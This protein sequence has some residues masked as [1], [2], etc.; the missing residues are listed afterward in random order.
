MSERSDMGI[1]VKIVEQGSMTRAGRELRMTAGAVTKRLAKLEARLGV[2]L[3]NRTTR[4]ISTTEAGNTFYEKSLQILNDIDWL[5][6]SV[7]MFGDT[8]TGMLKV[9][10]PSLFGRR[11]LCPLLQKFKIAYPDI[12]VH[13]QLTDRNVDL[14]GE[15][16]DVAVRSSDQ[17]DSTLVVRHLAHERRVVCGTPNYFETYG[18]PQTPKDLLNHNCLMLRFPGSRKYRWHFT[19]GE[20][21]ISYLVKG[22]MDS[23]SIEV[24]R[25]WTIAGL[26]LS[27]FSTAEVSDEL[28]AGVLQPVLTD[29]LPSIASYKLV[30]PR[31]QLMP[32]KTRS[33]VDFVSAQIGRE[34][35]WDQGL[36][37]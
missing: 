24:L 1:F 9:S 37:I 22:T 15:G 19:F 4:K 25:E 36:G 26:G 33:F 3:L 10:A 11:Q 30:L 31:R 29:F 27:M 18:R 2:R 14:V 17:V 21:E 34:P 35:Y 28:R 8:P 16:F 12:H 6:S 7:S 32:Q 13:L 20:E 23:N 5:E